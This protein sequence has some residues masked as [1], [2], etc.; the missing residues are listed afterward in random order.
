MH[1]ERIREKMEEQK[2]VDQATWRIEPYGWDK[3]DRTYYVLDDNRVYRLTEAPPPQPKKPK[4]VKKSTKAYRAGKRASKRRRLS[5]TVDAAEHLD[6]DQDSPSDGHEPAEDGLGGMKWECI[7][8]SLREVQ[9][10]IRTLQKT[11][12]GNEKVLR[13]QLQEHLIPILEKQEEA[14]I[15]KL[16]QKEKD[17]LN[18]WKMASAKR[19]SRIAH[20]IEQTKHDEKKREEEQHRL[21]EDAMARKLELEKSLFLQER[22]V[23]VKSRAQR[24]SDREEKKAQHAEELAQ[25]S[26]LSEGGATGRMSERQR[27]AEIERRKQELQ[28]LEEEEEDWYFDCVCGVVGQVDDGT[29]SIACE[30]CNVWQHSKCVGVPEEEADSDDF[31]FVCAACGRREADEKARPRPKATKIKIKVPR[32]SSSHDLASTSSRVVVEIHANRGPGLS[33]DTVVDESQLP[34]ATTKQPDLTAVKQQNGTGSAQPLK[35]EAPLVVPAAFHVPS[36]STETPSA[37]S[38]VPATGSRLT[39]D[40]HNTLSPLHSTPLGVRLN[41]AVPTVSATSSMNQVDDAPKSKDQLLAGP[42]RSPEGIEL[43]R[44]PPISTRSQLPVTTNG[45]SLPAHATLTP[46][47]FIGSPTPEIAG[48]LPLVPTQGGISPLKSSPLPAQGL[49]NGGSKGNTAHIFPPA[50]TLSPTPME[51]IMTPPVKSYDT[52]PTAD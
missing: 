6:S 10:F 32:P 35:T 37:R 31:H 24:K 19:S 34:I 20:R 16:K 3:D 23:R 38:T 51:Q 11:R 4:P 44:M 52:L 17:V 5:A 29:H 48:N 18:S 36:T 7:A 22:E 43:A 30:K 39:L 1:P 45:H 42:G 12:D 33:H 9:A 46:S 49:H 14:R 15:R 25:L 41:G 27:L 13:D 2:D 50:A 40:Q 47:P 26:E 8:V 28:A 21:A